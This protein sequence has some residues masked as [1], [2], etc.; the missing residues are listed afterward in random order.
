MN[1]LIKVLQ[2]WFY[3]DQ[4]FCIKQNDDYYY[5]YINGLSDPDKIG[6]LI[7]KKDKIL[8]ADYKKVVKEDEAIISLLNGNTIIVK[9]D[10][11]L[12]VDTRI[13]LYRSIEEPDDE[14]VSG[15]PH[16]G[17]NESFLNNV[18][19][20]RRMMRQRLNIEFNKIE[21]KYYSLIYL[22]TVNTNDLKELKG[23]LESISEII[24]IESLRESLKDNKYTFFQT[25][26]NTERPDT[27]IRKLKENKI[28]LILDGSP[29]ALYLPYTFNE[30]F[31]VPNDFYFNYA[32]SSINRIIR[33]AC[34]YISILLPGFYIMLLCYHHELI[35]TK[36]AISIQSSREGVPFP[37]IIEC[38]LL[39]FF[40]EILRE[41][42]N[43]I[44]SSLGSALSV[45]GAII[46]GQAAVDARIVSTSVVIIVAISSITSLVSN[47]MNGAIIMFRLL[48]LILSSILGVQGF[49]VGMSLLFIH[50]NDLKSLGHNYFTNMFSFNLNKIKSTYLRVPKEKKWL[51]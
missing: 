15:G 26:G 10:Y 48:I 42:G 11:Y 21:S 14:K 40:F 32:F 43:R 30:N 18:T 38:A 8:T 41:G 27:A 47:K 13:S 35:P 2:E 44:P 16:E 34:F 5:C 3:N 36:L 1:D 20:I 23:R 46:I 24:S 19:L 4:T 9:D 51:S 28:I 17:F 33:I 29:I 49:I 31:E 12:E 50:L 7:L 22:D 6:E 39:L 37:S 25:I 45:V